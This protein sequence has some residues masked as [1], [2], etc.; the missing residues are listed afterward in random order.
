MTNIRVAMIFSS[1][2]MLYAIFFFGLALVAVTVHQR[3]K[4]GI[5]A[6]DVTDSGGELTVQMVQMGE[7]NLT[8]ESDLFSLSDDEDESF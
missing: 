1:M 2:W 7:A 5:R 8:S 4:G 6:L 3:R